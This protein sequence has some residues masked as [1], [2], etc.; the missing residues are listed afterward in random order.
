MEP[1]VRHAIARLPA[2]PGVYRFRDGRGHVLYVGRATALR[3]RVSSYWRDLAGRQHLARMVAGVRAVEAV[4][5]ASVHE[6]AWLERNLLETSLPR[7][8]RTPGG[9]ENPVYVRLDGRAATPCLRVNHLAEPAP[10]GVRY[11]GPYLGGQRLR[12]AISALHRIWPLAYTGTRMSGTDRELA[13]R[14]GVGAGDRV[15]LV[16]ELCAVLDR[17]PDAVGRAR[18]RLAAARDRAAAAQA[19]ETAGRIQ[20][21]LRAL[22]WIAA[23]QRVT[24]DGAGDCTVHG[25]SD[26]VLVTFAVVGGRVCRWSQRRCAEAVAAPR[27]AA[28]PAGWR[29][30]AQRNAELAADLLT[31]TPC[32][33]RP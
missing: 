17:E 30:F 1:A 5:C 31:L 15:A 16:D 7:W 19:Y 32:Q 24:V 10:E 28:T 21:E 23:A 12:L 18:A 6:A 8:N 3:S 29:P 27:L 22:D 11:F 13:G 2:A 20:E 4:A 33:R 14:H 25:W 9:Q 26:G